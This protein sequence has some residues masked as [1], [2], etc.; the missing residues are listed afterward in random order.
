[1][2][3]R[4]VEKYGTATAFAEALGIHKSQISA[5]LTNKIDIT[6]SD[7]M[8]WSELLDINRSEIGEYFFCRES[9]ES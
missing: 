1:L 5:K 8:E 6:K 3:G 4:I 7:I 2:R 9:S